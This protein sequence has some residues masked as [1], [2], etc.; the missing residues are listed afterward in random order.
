MNKRQKYIILSGRNIKAK[1]LRTLTI[2]HYH[3]G[4]WDT[5]QSGKD[6]ARLL[7]EI[8]DMTDVLRTELL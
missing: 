8:T 6:A 2:D 7:D 4:G 1:K 3:A 5:E